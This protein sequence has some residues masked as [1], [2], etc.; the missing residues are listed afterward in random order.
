MNYENNFLLAGKEVRGWRRL[1]EFLLFPIQH[2]HE[3]V[4]GACGAC[5]EKDQDPVRNAH[6]QQPAR[7][8]TECAILIEPQDQQHDSDHENA[9]VY[10]AV[11][12]GNN[13]FFCTASCL[14]D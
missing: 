6:A 9:D 13:S 10:D 3:P 12:H 5:A 11:Y 8:G 2:L 4:N 1:R 14:A 7:A